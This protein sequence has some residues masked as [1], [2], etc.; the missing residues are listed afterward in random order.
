MSG[1]FAARVE[2]YSLC[3]SS[4]SSRKGGARFR[5]VTCTKILTWE[6]KKLLFLC[7]Y[8]QELEVSTPRENALKG[9]ANDGCLP[10]QHRRPYQED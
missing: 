5:D 1:S 2:G 7:A 6:S 4:S 9:G 8:A 3:L 10:P